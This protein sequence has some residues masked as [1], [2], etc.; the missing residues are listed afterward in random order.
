MRAM[1]EESPDNSP[2]E[3]P[4]KT[5]EELAAL[6]RAL[7]R[8]RVASTKVRKRRRQPRPER[9]TA[10][11]PAQVVK[12]EPKKKDLGPVETVREILYGEKGFLFWLNR[13]AYYAI[14]GVIGGW[15]VFRFV[16]PALGLYELVDPLGVP[17]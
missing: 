2:P 1:S 10:A 4:S 17:R 15:I 6:E 16:G 7:G 3:S 13:L 14:F 11:K 12:E 9:A 5:E 8:E